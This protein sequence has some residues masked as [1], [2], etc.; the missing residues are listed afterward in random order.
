[1]ITLGNQKKKKRKEEGKLF[2]CLFLQKKGA[3]N[4][5][6]KILSAS[7]VT[8]LLHI[9]PV[10]HEAA[11]AWRDD[12]CSKMWWHAQRESRLCLSIKASL[13]AYSAHQNTVLYML[14]TA[15]TNEGG[16][17]I[18]G[19]EKY[20]FFIFWKE[21]GTPLGS[22][23]HDI[24]YLPFCPLGNPVGNIK[25]HA[26]F[27]LMQDLSKSS[28]IKPVRNHILKRKSNLYRFSPLCHCKESSG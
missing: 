5:Q 11:R 23:T 17:L 6:G 28:N 4:L 18:T 14:I 13:F 22:F 1:M 19:K 16:D 21:H 3:C 8:S 10:D 20:F 7:V 15:K 26:R 12:R 27:C 9:N 25:T 2:L 24:E